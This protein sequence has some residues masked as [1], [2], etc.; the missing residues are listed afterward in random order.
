MTSAHLVW[1]RV[2][3]GWLCAAA[4]AGAHRLDEYLQAT[5][6]GVSQNRIDLEIDL[7]AGA[8]IAAADLRA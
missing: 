6:I 7:T 1:S 5:R 2:V 3:V 8:A 4:P